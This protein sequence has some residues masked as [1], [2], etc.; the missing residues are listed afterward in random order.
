MKIEKILVYPV[1]LPFAFDFSHSQ[2]RRSDAGNVVVEVVAEGGA[3]FGFGEGA[4]RTYVTGETPATVVD[5]IAAF[6]A[7]PDFCWDLSEPGQVRH[8]MHSFGHVRQGNAARCALELALIDALGRHMGRPAIDFFPSKA[9]TNRIFYGAA[10]P[11]AEA[12]V[13]REGCRIIRRLGIRR[14]K[15]K[16]SADI[17][18]NRQILDAVDAAFGGEAELKAD[19]NF[20]WDFPTAMA[21][22]PLLS[23]HRV[24][25]LEQPLA[26]EDPDRRLLASAMAE[27]GIV[28][29]ADESACTLADLK[30]IRKES[31][32]SM[33][34]MRLS[35]CGGFYRSLEMIDFLRGA[36]LPFQIACHLGESGILSAAG[37]ALGLLCGDAVYWDGCYDAFLL[38]ENLTTKDVSFGPGGAAGPLPG[39]GLG[40]E[41]SR[42]AL[43][44]LSE[45]S[46]PVAFKR[47]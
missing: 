33:I 41:V 28:L 44:K 2:R 36:A 6:T 16:F 37:R 35:K 31:S 12:A 43:L 22:I 27:A 30:R 46:E 42:G 38:R 9:R 17:E 5:Q 47:P 18:Q 45:G 29:M 20:A 19:V 1:R 10:L 11:L 24:K 3:C 34:N 21:H 14:L 23:R 13:I 25:V 15:L 40:V 26:R 32:F 8:L 4:P 39:S 7:A